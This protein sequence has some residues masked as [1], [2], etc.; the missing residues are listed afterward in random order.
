MEWSSSTFQFSTQNLIPSVARSGRRITAFQ[1]HH[2][3][4]KSF[5][6]RGYIRPQPAPRSI[7]IYPLARLLSTLNPRIELTKSS[8]H[9][10]FHPETPRYVD[11]FLIVSLWTT[12]LIYRSMGTLTAKH[13]DPLSSA[14][15]IEFSL[16]LDGHL[17][18]PW[19]TFMFLNLPLFCECHPHHC[20]HYSEPLTIIYLS[21]S[22][23]G[24]C[25]PKFCTR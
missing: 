18:F 25:L 3:L 12:P 21:S 9:R 20:P 23:L 16:Q 6:A 2:H 5:P 7:W 13:P 10:H 8:R 11:S 19:F 17:Q 22:P 14:L 4:P 24:S 15:P 1:T